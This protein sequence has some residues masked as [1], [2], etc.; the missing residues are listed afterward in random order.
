MYDLNEKKWKENPNDLCFP[1]RRAVFLRAALKIEDGKE[2][3]MDWGLLSAFLEISEYIR[4]SRSFERLLHQLSLNNAGSFMRSNL[5]SDEVIGMNVDYD[6][7]VKLMY[8]NR[9][10]EKFNEITAP[11]IHNNWMDFNETGS[12]F[13]KE[14]KKLNYS[15]RLDNIQA[16][17]RIKKILN[18]VI[19][20]KYEMKEIRLGI[21]QNMNGKVGFTEEFMNIITIPGKG[22][23]QE[24]ID[25]FNEEEK[26]RY[27]NLKLLAEIEHNGWMECRLIGGWI[28]GKDRS[29]YHRIHNCIVPFEKLSIKEKTKDKKQIDCYA[30]YLQSEQY[31]IVKL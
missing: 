9:E 15:G 10:E 26:I 1:V 12:S 28:Y 18:S 20:L 4:G 21:R 27:E 14:Y 19:G 25:K 30:E 8:D 17:G 13:Y 7:F 29:D 2:L 22:E 31:K 6:E 5:P 23:S 16:A 11:K 3:D 24:E